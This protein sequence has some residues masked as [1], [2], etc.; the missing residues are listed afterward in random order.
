MSNRDVTLVSN[1]FFAKDYVPDPAGVQDFVD[2][3]KQEY[4][5]RVKTPSKSSRN[6]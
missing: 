2:K 1:L 6:L 4:G 3:A 5:F